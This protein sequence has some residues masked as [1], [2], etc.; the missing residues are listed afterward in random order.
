MDIVL[1]CTYF[2]IVIYSFMVAPKVFFRMFPYRNSEE[3]HFL[4]F[5]G[6]IILGLTMTGA[7]ARIYIILKNRGK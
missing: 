3:Y 6:C 5:I 2:L 7:F 4:Y 1:S